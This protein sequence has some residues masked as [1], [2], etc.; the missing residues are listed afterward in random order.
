MAETL[1][2]ARRQAEQAAFN[3]RRTFP[4]EIELTAGED[5]LA[6]WTRLRQQRRGWPVVLGGAQDFANVAAQIADMA[7]RGH[8]PERVL[9]AAAGLQF[10]DDM[11]ARR[12]AD[13]KRLAKT[14]RAADPS[15][16]PMPSF[17]RF[18]PPH[19]DWQAAAGAGLSVAFE[20]VVEEGRARRRAHEPVY[21]AVLPTEDGAEAPAYLGFGGWNDC[22]HPHEHVA[23]LRYWREKYGVEL[24]GLSGDTLN[25]RAARRAGARAEALALA[26]EQYEYCTDIVEQ[27]VASIEAL[28]ATLMAEDWWFFWWD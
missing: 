17:E 10:P 21:V 7:E 8:R 20:Y 22:P 28:A 23:A 14:L 12:A 19:G 1:E 15:A 13:L 26:M 11:R 2:H 25:L 24:V 18:D 5:A 6:T 16:P 27:G 9:A 4:Y 3:A